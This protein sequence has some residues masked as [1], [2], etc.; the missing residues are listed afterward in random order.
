MTRRRYQAILAAVLTVVAVGLVP[1]A[2]AAPGPDH[3]ARLRE[4]AD[5]LVESA[6]RG[7][8]GWAWRRD[9][10]AAPAPTAPADTAPAAR[11]PA[12]RRPP[13]VEI[14]LKVTAAAGL[15]LHLAGELLD[16]PAY[17]DAAQEAARTLMTA[18]HRTGQVPAAAT[19]VTRPVG[20]PDPAVVPDRSATVA[21]LGLLL[22][23]VE[24]AD[25]QK[26]DLRL[27]A[28]ALRAAHWL[29][30]QQTEAGGWPTFAPGS[31]P[32]E[33][34]RRLIL[35]DDP[36]YR[37]S[38][39]ALVLAARVLD[40]GELRRGAGRAVTQLLSLRVERSRSPG[41]GLWTPGFTL[42]GEP[43]RG[44]APL[45]YFVDVLASR[46]AMEALLAAHL[47]MGDEEA[48][49]ALDLAA[50]SLDGLPQRDGWWDRW[51]DLFLRKVATP[52][53]PRREEGGAPVGGGGENVFNLD[54][55]PGQQP[56]PEDDPNR[57]D[58]GIPPVLEA[59][60]AIRV[61]GPQRYLERLEDDLGLN[62]RVALVLTGLS[63]DALTFRLP[64][65]AAE[66]EAYLSEGES[67]TPLPGD[68]P[69]SVG[70]AYG[71][72][73]AARLQRQQQE[74]APAEADEPVRGKE[75]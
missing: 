67:M 70:Q 55:R 57:G 47:G 20:R 4:A 3:A 23:L 7:R 37:N 33:A 65:T 61:V 69:T 66:A 72:L 52:P 22:V 35:L 53:E 45:P 6:V 71:L 31:G 43:V 32:G 2:P 24:D 29:A 12:R 26:P 49:R 44:I 17:R 42:G 10:A 60:E 1:P 14:D 16:E 34:T 58:F 15:V 64:K 36:E 40:R 9:E 75:Q 19:V 46:Y 59:V 21:A 41:R 51:Y 73:L 48:G 8:Y 62:R 74:A 39:L 38:T 27:N 18:Q 11:G 56:D 30:G 13:A 68:L 63:E 28:A 54:G 25:P 5:R 50:K